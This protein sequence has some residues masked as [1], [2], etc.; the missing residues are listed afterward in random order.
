MEKQRSDDFNQ[1]A[2]HSGAG[3]QT[4]LSGADNDRQ[5]CLSSCGADNDRQECLSSYFVLHV[6]TAVLLIAA[7][8]A[9]FFFAS[10]EKTMGDVQRIVYFHVPLAWFGMISF[11]AMA[12]SGVFYLRSRDACWDN[13]SQAFAEVGWLCCTLTMLAGSIWARAAWNTWWTWDPRLTTVFLL[14]A[15]YSGCLIL[16]TNLEDRHQSARFRAVLAI[17]GALDLPIIVL[18][19]RWFRGMHPVS[20]QME[21]SMR[22]ILALGITA[23]TLLFAILVLRRRTQ[24]E[25]FHRIAVLEQQAGLES[26]SS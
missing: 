17:V 13:W 24:L 20:P 4:F 12:I 9:I 15:M 18:A 10:T 2:K 14:W 3:G 21:P 7:I 11:L 1:E 8:I 23:F 6:V 25:L 16:R 5:E 22:A 26:A 19:T